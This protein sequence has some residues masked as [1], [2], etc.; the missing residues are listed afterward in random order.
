MH[1][2]PG[3]VAAVFVVTCTKAKAVTFGESLR[4]AECDA[5][6]SA[7]AVGLHAGALTLGAELATARRSSDLARRAEAPAV[8]A[9]A[10]Q[11]ILGNSEF[12]S[13]GAAA[14]AGS[15]AA[16]EPSWHLEPFGTLV[17]RIAC[18]IREL[19]RPA[20]ALLEDRR[21]AVEAG[22]ATRM[23]AEAPAHQIDGAA[24]VGDRVAAGSSVSGRRLAGAVALR[25]PADAC[26]PVE[27]LVIVGARCVDALTTDEHLEQPAASLKI[28]FSGWLLGARRTSGHA[29]APIAARPVASH[30]A[31][32]AGTNVARPLWTLFPSDVVQARRTPFRSVSSNEY[33]FG[34][35]LGSQHSSYCG[36]YRPSVPLQNA[37]SSVLV[38][39]VASGCVT[40][41]ADASGGE[42]SGVGFIITAASSPHAIPKETSAAPRGSAVSRR[43][44]RVWKVIPVETISS[45]DGRHENVAGKPCETR[46]RAF[47][48][49]GCYSAAAAP[50][51]A[52]VEVP[53]DPADPADVSCHRVTER[54]MS[55]VEFLARLAGAVAPPRY[56]GRLHGV[57]AAR[58][59]WRGSVVPRPPN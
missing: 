52:R 40:S 7:T 37:S 20:G 26:E 4:A 28:D 2:P 17:G 29:R 51:A 6:G 56:H 22:G 30:V 19:R 13:H 10:I 55:P 23:E 47:R 54:V 58:H 43:Q 46:R 32:A 1:T 45:R 8:G 15:A 25:R 42:P 9:L 33:C 53:H 18:A 48:V 34:A 31:A 44:R 59:A 3:G 12:R 11:P 36:A 5:A 50:A 16:H 27:A 57:F 39:T 35:E 41:S 24:T 14:G 21:S 38:A 49:R